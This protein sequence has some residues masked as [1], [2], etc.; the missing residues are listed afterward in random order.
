MGDDIECLAEYESAFDAAALRGRVAMVSG[1]GTGI[2]FRISEVLMRHGCDV[3]IGSRRL[4]VVQGAS[5]RLNA[6]AGAW[7]SSARCFAVQMDV[8]S[9]DA[10]AA[11]VR[12]ALDRF[13]RI[14]V[15]VN[16][17]AGNFLCPAE[18]LSANAWRTVLD[19]DATG[20]FLLS[21]AVFKMYMKQHGGSIIN[22]TATLHWNG[23]L[24]Q[25]HAG[26]AK[27]AIEGLTTHLANEWG[28]Y[29][30]RVNNLAPGPIADTVGFRK[31][32]G[33]LSENMRSKWL[34]R[35]ALR[36]FGSATEVAQ[37]ALFLAS[38]ASSY[39]TGATLTVDGGSWFFGGG[40]V[41]EAMREMPSAKL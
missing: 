4:A 34:N 36:R 13:G 40:L 14:D 17:A 8:R 25:A 11:A 16:G 29:N 24:F 41:G 21:Q 3:V 18:K 12:A 7:G 22:I 9:Q 15:L 35:L 19:I 32:G 6:A 31:L 30:V 33:E 20:C 27:A 2:C 38:D 5:E 23:E 39:V 37:G 1:G 26:A 28:Q 10:V